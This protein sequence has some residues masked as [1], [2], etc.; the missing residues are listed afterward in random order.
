MSLW[1]PR[2]MKT[3][4]RDKLFPATTHA[5]I[6]NRS[7]L[8]R[9]IRGLHASFPAPKI[10][11]AF[12]AKANPLHG[13]LQ[14]IAAEGMGCETA[15]IA[16]F[17]AAQRA[18][19]SDKVVF[20]SPVKTLEELRVALYKPCYLNVDNFEELS[21]C[22]ALHAEKPI[23]ATV[24][25]RINPQSGGG[26]IECTS[27]ATMTSKFG[28]G[29]LDHRADIIAAFA[30]HSFLKMLHVHTG[31]QG[32]G[33]DAMVH[34]VKTIYEL[35]Q[36]IGSQVTVI[37]IGGGLSVNFA[38]D[39]VVPT[40][41][42]Y[43]EALHAAV[44]GLFDGSRLLITEFGRSIVAKAGILASRVEYTKVNGGRRIIQQHIGADL[45]VRTVWAPNQWP[46]RVSIYDEH[47]VEKQEDLGAT[48]VAGPCCIGGCMV[49]IDK[50]LPAA[51]SMSDV[52]VVKDVGGYYHSSF[53][54]YN[55]RQQPPSYLY[56]EETETLTLIQKGQTLEDML[57]LMS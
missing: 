31:S 42:S 28:I 39:A 15:S 34:G 10:L 33:V 6:V 8:Q 37:D 29:L 25:I 14:V 40:F 21:R 54:M 35:A 3:V 50:M 36:E 32:M 1:I 46:L 26:N 11:H 55:L 51:T 19:P 27:T 2:C 57:N 38:S 43:Y 23:V 56:D 30:Q 49:A 17:S 20:D 9:V 12:A 5:F 16:E 7:E 22:A 24:G 52:V 41:A 18:F 47:G 13:V 4:A 45:C 53:S 48:N 44:P